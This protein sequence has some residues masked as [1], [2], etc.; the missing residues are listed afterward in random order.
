MQP[1]YD[2]GVRSCRMLVEYV[3]KDLNENKNSQVGTSDKT[4]SGMFITI[5]IKRQQSFTPYT[6]VPISASE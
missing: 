1:L 3:N 6:I 2:A 5:N 4:S